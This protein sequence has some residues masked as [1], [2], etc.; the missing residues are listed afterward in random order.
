MKHMRQAWVLMLQ[1]WRKQARE[2]RQKQ[3]LK[4]DKPKHNGRLYIPD[5]E[6][7]ISAEDAGD[8]EVASFPVSDVCLPVSLGPYA[9]CPS[10]IAVMAKFAAFVR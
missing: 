10:V 7:G 6:R 5:I 4:L 2:Y 8:P 9:M 3:L 1:R